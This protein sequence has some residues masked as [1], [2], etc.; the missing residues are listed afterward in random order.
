MVCYVVLDINSER[1]VVV[2][3]HMAKQVLSEKRKQINNK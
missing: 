2:D 3:C 1:C